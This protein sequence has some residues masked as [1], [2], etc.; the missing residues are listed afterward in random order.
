MR[1]REKTYNVL[2]LYDFHCNVVMLVFLYDIVN[3]HIFLCSGV[4]VCVNYII[5]IIILLATWYP[6]CRCNSHFVVSY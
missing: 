2:H 4:F 6:F 1:E 3:L 5:F